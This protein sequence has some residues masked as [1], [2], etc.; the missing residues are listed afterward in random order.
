[1]RDVECRSADRFRKVQENR[2]RLS[3]S[4]SQTRSPVSQ[5]SGQLSRHSITS[6]QINRNGSSYSIR[7]SAVRERQQ[8][9]FLEAKKELANVQ[10]R[11]DL[12]NTK[13]KLNLDL[14]KESINRKNQ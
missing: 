9:I 8:F 13:R 2:Y 4:R 10:M 6:S 12:A 7:N 1:M 3:A 11:V 14:L 5:R